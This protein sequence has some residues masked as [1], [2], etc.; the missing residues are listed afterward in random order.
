MIFSHEFL[1]NHEIKNFFSLI[2]KI[3]DLEFFFV[4]VC[5]EKIL[6]TFLKTFDKIFHEK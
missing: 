3:V 1:L 5:C 4:E 2:K 6:K